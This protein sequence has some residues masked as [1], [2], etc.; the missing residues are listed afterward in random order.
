M[1]HILITIAVV[2]L[3]GCGESQHSA[4]APE[5]K[6]VEPV[7]EV[8]SQPSP[9]PVE[10]KPTTPPKAVTANKG[11]DPAR[12]IKPEPPAAN[13]IDW[14]DKW[15]RSIH[16]AA[17]Q[18]QI[19]AVKQH[20]AAGTDVNAKNSGGWT[21][22]HTAAYYGRTVIAELLIAKGADILCAGLACDS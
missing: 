3:V 7:A 22:L 13:A 8:P 15:L 6:P 20:I 1:K 9:P 18:G 2:V 11:A 19:E 5:A 10:A 17:Q 4:P 16:R 14:R 21:P 12:G